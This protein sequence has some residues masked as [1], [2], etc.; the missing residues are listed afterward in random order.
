MMTEPLNGKYEC[1]G[2]NL[3]W[4]K[5]AK[6]RLSTDASE[7]LEDVK[8]ACEF[9]LEYKDKEGFKDLWKKR[10]KL[11][12]EDEELQWELSIHEHNFRICSNER[13][14]LIAEKLYNEWL[15]KLAFKDMLDGGDKQ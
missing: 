2:Q 4:D 5:L 1:Y 10:K 8:L 15:F 13:E 9:Y 11:F 3:W 12:S 6:Q 14:T 7:V